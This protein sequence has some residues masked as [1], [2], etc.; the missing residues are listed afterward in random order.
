MADA[1]SEATAALRAHGQAID[2][3]HRRLA[4]IPG[5]DTVKLKMAVEKF[6]T[7]HATF[8]DDALE[9]VVH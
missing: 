3:L 1:K 2:D 8:E 7:A 4:A 9:C 6:K 5:A